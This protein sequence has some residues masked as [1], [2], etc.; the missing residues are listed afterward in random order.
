MGSE[1]CIRDSLGTYRA[2]PKVDGS[3]TFGM[4]AITLSGEGTVLRV[5]QQVA[6]DPA[7]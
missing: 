2:N 3:I 6:V 4:N 7:F 1:M 5:G